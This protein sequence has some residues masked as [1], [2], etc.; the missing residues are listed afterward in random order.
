[1]PLSIRTRLAVRP[2]PCRA[3]TCSLAL[4]IRELGYLPTSRAESLNH[5]LQRRTRVEIPALDYLLLQTLL[6]TIRGLLIYRPSLNVV[7]VFVSI[8][9]P[10]KAVIDLMDRSGI[11]IL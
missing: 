9:P 4:R 1:M 5:F 8:C 7:H 11:R 3:S 10:R 2:R 6:K